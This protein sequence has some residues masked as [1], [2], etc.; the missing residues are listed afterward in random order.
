MPQP[1][2]LPAPPPTATVIVVAIVIAIP[3]RVMPCHH[4]G[5]CWPLRDG[6]K[7]CGDRAESKR[8]GRAV[9]MTTRRAA[10]GS[11]EGVTA[12]ASPCGRPGRGIWIAA[13]DATLRQLGVDL[14]ESRLMASVWLSPLPC[15]NVEGRVDCGSRCDAAADG[16]R[17]RGAPMTDHSVVRNRRL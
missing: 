7:D 16:R 5:V 14:Q 12:V 13:T 8:A 1:K 3:C 10:V 9:C 11:G 17:P 2:K 4:T 6:R 15:A